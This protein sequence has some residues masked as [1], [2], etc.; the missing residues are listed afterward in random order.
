[1]IP[2]HKGEIPVVIL[3]IPFLLGIGL[4]LNL[5]PGTGI[6]CL[7]VIFF[8]LSTVF[9]IL[10]LN[11]SRFG[12]YKQ[13][14]LGGIFIFLI[15]LLFGWISAS[16]YSELNKSD[17]FSK[18]P[19]QYLVVKITNEPNLKNGLLRF[20]AAVE[21]CINNGKKN[22]T[23][24]TL[25]ITIKDSSA[26][27]LYYGDQLLI[28]AKYA[29]IDPP[30]NPAEFNY[31]KYLAN[32][33]IYYQAFLYPKQYKLLST[34]TGNPLIAH[35]LRLRQ[36]LVEKLKSNMADTGAFAVASTL[37]LGYKTDLSDD[38]KQ[39]YSKTGTMYVLSVSGGQVTIIY[40]LLTFIL[41]FLNPYK[42][43]KV[44]KAI[45]IVS[46]IGYY[47]MLRAFPFRCAG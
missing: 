12:L 43:G 19:S 18:I 28:P 16:R 29:T 22:S 15:L 32:Q 46:I 47:A 9:I 4:G 30:F 39:A 34:N 7:S 17:H 5:P 8:T 25:L 14:W 35:S 36:R 41:K 21:E 31:K 2:N 33:N 3:L 37:I 10:N 23:S 42:H 26:K 6:F 24:G 11:Y 1:M 13:R 38:I 40:I 45:I 20:T 27:K 44:V